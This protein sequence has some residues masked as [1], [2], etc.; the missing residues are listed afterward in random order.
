[1]SHYDEELNIL[2]GAIC[3]G[4][5]QEV[6]YRY[7]QELLAPRDDM[8]LTEERERGLISSLAFYIRTSGFM[9][10]V[11]HYWYGDDDGVSDAETPDLAIRLP[12][13]GKYL[14]LEAKP[15]NP[16]DNA[17]DK[18]GYDLDKLMKPTN[19]QNKRNGFLALGFAFE[20]TQHDTFQNKYQ[21]LSEYITTNYHFREFKISPV[22]LKNVGDTKLEYAMVGLWLRK[23]R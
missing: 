21:E 12:R 23:L 14:F 4:V 22:D 17:I 19:P 15:I 1:M 13:V 2:F 20:N 18:A 16:G 7:L 6:R 11:E 5:R 9:V 8:R 10:H 3:D